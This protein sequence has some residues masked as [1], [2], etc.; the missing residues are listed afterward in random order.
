MKATISA[1]LLVGV[2]R[3]IFR[4]RKTLD[5]IYVLQE[6]SSKGIL[7]PHKINHLILLT[8]APLVYSNLFDGDRS[9]GFY[10]QIKTCPLSRDLMYLTSIVLHFRVL[11]V[12]QLRNRKKLK[13]N[14]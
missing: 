14:R 7:L 3:H 6:V 12:E 2:D 8:W 5:F 10:L 13:A 4:F 11:N 1:L 9:S